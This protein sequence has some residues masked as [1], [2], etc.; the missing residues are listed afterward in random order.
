MNLKGRD[1]DPF[2]LNANCCLVCLDNQEMREFQLVQHYLE[3]GIIS[4][5]SKY[6]VGVLVN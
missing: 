5:T 3:L 4:T 1:F 6:E 2:Y